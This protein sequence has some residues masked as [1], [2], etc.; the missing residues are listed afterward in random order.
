MVYFYCKKGGRNEKEWEKKKIQNKKRVNII[1]NDNS[2]IN[3]NKFG[4]RHYT[5]SKR[6]LMPLPILILSYITNDFNRKD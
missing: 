6:G 1:W 5:I 2:D 3:A 4:I